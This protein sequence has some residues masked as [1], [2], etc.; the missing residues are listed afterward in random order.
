MVGITKAPMV[1]EPI[2][3]TR[4]NDVEK[5][6]IKLEEAI[7]PHPDLFKLNFF[8]KMSVWINQGAKYS[9]AIFIIINLIINIGGKMPTSN[10]KKTTRTGIVKG[11]IGAVISIVALFF[12][13][14]ITPELQQTIIGV[15]VG[16][17]SIVE[18]V[19]GYFT[20]KPDTVENGK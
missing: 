12:T 19:Q 10:D 16:I 17:W 2:V 13:I 8:D 14:D 4:D 20:N 11:I 5:Y 9:K 7:E 18:F 15:I 3:L 1:K 6:K